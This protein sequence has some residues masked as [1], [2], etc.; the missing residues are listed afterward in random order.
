MEQYYSALRYLKKSLPLE[1]TVHVNRVKTPKD[2]DG[3]CCFRND[4]FYI[5]IDKTLPEYYAIDVLLHEMAHV[6]AWDKDKLD[7]HGTNWGK[8]YSLVYRTFLEWNK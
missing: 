8:A 2:R 3:D 7:Y 5:R 1:H 6:L 4:K